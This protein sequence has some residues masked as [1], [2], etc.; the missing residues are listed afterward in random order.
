FAFLT[1]RTTFLRLVYIT[2]T[3][4]N[5]SELAGYMSLLLPIV[6]GLYFDGV[7]LF[8]KRILLILVILFGATLILAQSRSS[9][10]A[11]L[12]PFIL[13][14]NKK[15]L[16]GM[17]IAGVFSLTIIF[18]T[19]SLNWI[20]A[21]FFQ[22][23]FPEK[24]SSRFVKKNKISS[25]GHY[26]VNQLMLHLI[27]KNPV[28]G[29]GLNNFQF[30]TNTYMNLQKF[31]QGSYSVSTRYT[32]PYGRASHN[33]YLSIWVETGTLGL[34]ALIILLVS[35]FV[36]LLKII[37]SRDGKDENFPRKSFGKAVLGG[38]ISY[39]F[40]NFYHDLGIHEV[41]F[42]I[43]LSLAAALIY[44]IKKQEKIKDA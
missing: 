16:W 4:R 2:S 8:K 37:L 3:F 43:I 24:Y 5:P 17:I 38:F 9:A 23:L 21:R 31:Q 42:W 22:E 29:V 18:F 10:I 36:G 41:R 28:L 40:Y 11:V 44:V 25:A 7:Q 14:L 39:L 33:F 30:H 20:G 26:Y 12:I 15:R 1:G 13:Y 34:I 19:P 32:S 27:K 35:I 6:Y